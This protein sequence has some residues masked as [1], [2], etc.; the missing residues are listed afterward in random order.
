MFSRLCFRCGRYH[1]AIYPTTDGRTCRSCIIKS[2]TINGKPVEVT[3]E[4]L[5]AAYGEG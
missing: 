5:V 1:V 3:T 2:L 4:L